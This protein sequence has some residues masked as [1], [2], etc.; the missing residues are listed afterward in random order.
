[1]T[2]SNSGSNPAS[3]VE[4]RSRMYGLGENHRN[5]EIFPRVSDGFEFSQLV[6]VDAISLAQLPERFGARQIRLMRAIRSRYC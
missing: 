1:M 2:Q 5:P 4:H 3:L 6:A